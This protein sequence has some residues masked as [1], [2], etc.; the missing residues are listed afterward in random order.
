VAPSAE[1]ATA[2]FDQSQKDPALSQG[3][4]VFAYKV[5]R[6]PTDPSSYPVLLVSYLMG[7][8]KYSS[9]ETTD[10]VKAYFTYVVSDEGQQL[11]S[12]QAGSAPIGPAVKKEDDAAIQAIGG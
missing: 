4:N 11:A 7:C 9:T 12:E 10:L 6:V 8:T 1:G 3:K 2:D 5:Q